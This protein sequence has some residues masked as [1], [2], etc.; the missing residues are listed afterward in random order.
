MWGAGSHVWSSRHIFLAR[1]AVTKNRSFGNYL[2]PLH[3]NEFFLR[4]RVSMTSASGGGMTLLST[5]ARTIGLRPR[6]R[7]VLTAALLVLSPAV[8]ARGQGYEAM[9][10]MATRADLTA[11]ADRLSRGSSEDRTKAGALRTR[12]REGDFRP[13]DRIALAIEGNV[14]V[15]DTIPVTAGLRLCRL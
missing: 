1:I 11:L 15:S 5:P 13:G 4:S 3:L 2:L 6:I 7:Y 8:E 9:Q 12:L 14:Q 10:P